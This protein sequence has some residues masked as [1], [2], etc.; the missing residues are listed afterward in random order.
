MKFVQVLS[1]KQV[2]KHSLKK[3][4]TGCGNNMEPRKSFEQKVQTKNKLL[5][6]LNNEIIHL[7]NSKRFPVI[8]KYMKM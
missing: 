3:E 1:Q 7:L 8:N 4:Y 2:L 6:V 5:T